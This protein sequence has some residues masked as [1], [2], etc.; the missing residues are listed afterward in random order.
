MLN[1]APVDL[2]PP[3]ITFTSPPS[4]AVVNAPLNVVLQVVD[5]QSLE[6]VVVKFDANGDGVIQGAGEIVTPTANGGGIFAA[7]FSALS[8]ASGVRQIRVEASDF[9]MNSRVALLPVVFGAAGM[10]GDL[11]DDDRDGFVNLLERAFGSNPSVPGNQPP[12]TAVLDTAGGRIVF[13]YTHDTAQTGISTQVQ[14]SDDLVS[15]NSVGVTEMVIS[16]VGTISRIQA[17]IPLNGAPQRFVRVAVTR[18]P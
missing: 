16:T 3:A 7:T 10:G 6:S 15:W 12:M 11:D 18:V 9:S 1:H 13:T 17:S 8:G 4:G 2:Q 5:D 14:V